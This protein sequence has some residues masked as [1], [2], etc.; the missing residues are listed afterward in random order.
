MRIA[1]VA[2]RQLPGSGVLTV[3][4][5]LALALAR[6][7]HDVDLWQL[8]DWDGAG[9][10]ELTGRLRQ[11]GVTPV[12][13]PDRN[14][15]RAAQQAAAR[16]VSERGTEVVHLHSVFVPRNAAIARG[17]KVPYAL[18]PHG[19]YH[20]VSLAR[21]RMRKLVYRAAVECR[22]IREA[23]LVPVL[24][25]DEANH[26]H[27]LVP[28][29]RTV[30]IPNGVARRPPTDLDPTAFRGR[31][32]VDSRQRLAVYVGRLDVQ[33]KG[34]DRLL[35]GA[36]TAPEW[37]LLLVGPDHRGGRE[38]LERLARELD[39]RDRIGFTGAVGPRDVHAALAAADLFTLT[40]R[41]EGQPMAL[42][43]A[44]SH[45]TPALVTP[46]VERVVPVAASGAGWMAPPAELGPI[47]QRLA[48]ANRGDW[49]GHRAAARRLAARYDWD[50]VAE[51]YEE[52]YAA[53]AGATS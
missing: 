27:R 1:Q 41:W 51:R 11:G 18:S 28:A 8:H 35:R 38:I 3:I 23:S 33:H 44:L 50:A 14:G 5:E 16:T 4:V 48:S 6:R 40:S 53:S 46:V 49:S 45:G 24:T 9:F 26:V 22:L 12:R 47:L 31:Y 7:G 43:E 13:M 19:G 15:W 39:L 52:V 10:D 21:R 30:V 32:G 25:Q 29:A 37:R 17:L 20:P 36:A 2:A 34:L 42:L